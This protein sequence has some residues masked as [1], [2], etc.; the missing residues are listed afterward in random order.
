MDTASH[1]F[2]DGFKVQAWVWAKLRLKLPTEYEV[3]DSRS[4]FIGLGFSG[5]ELNRYEKVQGDIIIQKKG[6]NVAG[7]EVCA[8]SDRGVSVGES[9]ER[10]FAGSH[11]CFVIRTEED[12]MGIMTFAPSDTMRRYLM[13]V[14]S[15]DSKDH[16]KESY[17]WL[18]STT[19]GGLRCGITFDGFIQELLDWEP[20]SGE[21][22][23]EEEIN[24]PPTVREDVPEGL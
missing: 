20:E 19:V 14:D 4:Y 11:Y 17:K 10:E 5:S 6:R 12:P 22:M 13:S 16:R 18:P 23:I 7:I 8:G 1:N 21:V 9:K 3:I 15:R 24:E 2:Q